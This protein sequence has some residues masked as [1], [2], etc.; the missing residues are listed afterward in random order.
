MRKIWRLIKKWSNKPSYNGWRLEQLYFAIHILNYYNTFVLFSRVK[1]N[2]AV[3]VKQN[4]GLPSIVAITTFSAKRGDKLQ[5]S[6]TY[7]TSSDQK[8]SEWLAGLIDGDGYFYSA[9]GKFNNFSI[10]MDS[11]DQKV[12]EEVKERFGGKIYSVKN[13]NAL[14]YV[15]SKKKELLVLIHVINGLI[16]NPKRLEQMNNY[17]IKYS[18]ELKQPVPLTYNNGWLSGFIDSDGSIYFSESSGQVFIGISQKNINLLE[19]LVNL[20]GGK[21]ISVSPK[22]DAYKYVVYRKNDLFNLVDN[23]FSKYPLR[24]LKGERIKLIK[25]FYIARLY[26]KNT[27]NNEWIIFKNKWDNYNSL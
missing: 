25:Q 8:F 13:A 11:R 6:R 4:I 2:R 3:D 23:Y 15:L 1:T 12:L 27:N 7:S 14:R 20:Y 22:I 24:T 26:L 5:H 19:S 16:R 21:I 9:S 17:C 18:V 10:T